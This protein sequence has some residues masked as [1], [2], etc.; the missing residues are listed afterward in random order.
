[1]VTSLQTGRDCRAATVIRLL[2]SDLARPWTVAQMAALVGV[3]DAHLRRLFARAMGASPLQVLCDL[4]L[5]AA[6]RLL[7]DPSLRVKEI[8]VRVGLAD[9]SHFSRDFR[10]RFGVSP[11]EYRMQRAGSTDF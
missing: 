11:T 1:M 10:C 4:R 2:E 5:Q 7:A 9:A 8:Q 3:S 6:A